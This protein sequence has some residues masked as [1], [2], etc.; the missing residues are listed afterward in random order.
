MLAQ[1]ERTK[2]NHRCC[3]RRHRDRRIRHR[4]SD[5]VDKWAEEEGD[6]R[7]TNAGTSAAAASSGG[8]D[9]IRAT[10]THFAGIIYIQPRTRGS[11]RLSVLSERLASTGTTCSPRQAVIQDDAATTCDR[12][13]VSYS[14]YACR[15][16]RYVG[17][18]YVDVVY[19]S[20]DDGD[21]ARSFLFARFSGTV[22]RVFP[23]SHIRYRLHRAKPRR[24]SSRLFKVRPAGYR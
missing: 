11:L 5:Q 10:R 13:Q 17:A 7:R 23:V 18:R 19:G 14:P 9:G 4:R 20:I 21:N 24:G 6:W 1:R 3:R 15:L 2:R 22:S 12:L 16:R 8:G